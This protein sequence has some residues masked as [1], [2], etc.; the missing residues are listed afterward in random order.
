MDMI[1]LNVA[2]F[3]FDSWHIL[4]DFRKKFEKILHNTRIQDAAAV[5][6][7]KDNMVLSIIGSMTG[8]VDLHTPII[9][10]P[11]IHPRLK[12]WFPERKL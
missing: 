8:Q 1:N 10:P 12:P 4:D 11:S 6:G 5:F 7:Y 2:F 3:D 9:P